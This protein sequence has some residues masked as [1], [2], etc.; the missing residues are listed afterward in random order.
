[1]TLTSHSFGA[2]S[3]PSK[4]RTFMISVC[5]WAPKG[6]VT[7]MLERDKRPGMVMLRKNREYAN[8]VA[9]KLIEEKRQELKDGT[10]RRDLLS[11]L[12]SYCVFSVRLGTWRDIQSLSQGEFYHATGMATERR[13]DCRPSSV[14]RPPCHYVQ[15]APVHPWCRTIMF[16]GHETTAKS[17]SFCNYT[18]YDPS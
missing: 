4:G 9:A 1:V 5:K 16:A 13:R 7:W 12:G 10:S 6:F 18:T 15:M 2:F 11:L 14:R 17:V 3:S 8:E